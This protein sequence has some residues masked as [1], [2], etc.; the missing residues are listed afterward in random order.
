MEKKKKGFHESNDFNVIQRLH[1]LQQNYIYDQNF[2]EI[3]TLTRP[4]PHHIWSSFS[5]RHIAFLV[6]SGFIWA[7]LTLLQPGCIK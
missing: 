3:L 4:A 7:Q 6:L 2:L 1:E 5:F